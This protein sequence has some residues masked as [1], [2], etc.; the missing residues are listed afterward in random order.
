MA[1]LGYYRKIGSS[2]LDEPYDVAVR[3]ERERYIVCGI[4]QQAFDSHRWDQVAYHS[5]SEHEPI[6]LDA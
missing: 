6:R 3:N 4:C 2:E 5:Q 1:T